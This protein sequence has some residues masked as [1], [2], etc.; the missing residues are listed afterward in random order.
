MCDFDTGTGTGCLGNIQVLKMV[1]KDYG[2]SHS[3][4][5]SSSGKYDGIIDT[6]ECHPD[7]HC[8]GAD[9]L[10]T[11]ADDEW[12]DIFPEWVNVKNVDFY[13]YPEK[14]F[15]HA[16]KESND[17]LVLNS[18]VRIRLTLGLAWEKRK[19]IRGPSGDTTITTTV[20]LSR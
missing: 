1:G 20:N 6:W 14:D 10:P 8:T 11:G 4:A 2:M 13:P 15:R 17:S 9:N 3:G 19:K 16:W 5:V 12:V 18:Y 7:Y